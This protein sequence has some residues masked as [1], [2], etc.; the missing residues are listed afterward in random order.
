MTTIPPR[1]VPVGDN[2]LSELNQMLDWHAG[3]LLPD[4][5]LIGKL[6]RRPNKRVEPQSIPDR[7]IESLNQ[8]FP[9]A[10]RKVLEIGCF[11]GI[12]TIGLR[13]MGA[14]VTAVDVRPI[15]VVKTLAR[16]SYHGYSASVFQADAESLDPSLGPVDLVF[17]FG[18]LYHLL[19]PVEHIMALG[20]TT[21]ALY[22]DTH[23]AWENAKI[24]T[25]LVDGESY[26]SAVYTEGGWSDPFSGK[27]AKSYWLTQDSL[28][29]ALTRAGFSSIAVLEQRAERNGPRVLIY[30]TSGPLPPELAGRE[31]VKL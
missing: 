22:L 12:H 30:A 15:N 31:P 26:E 25:L 9:L 24:H 2:H 17:H 4:G 7:R 18:V 16:L 10:G 8:F 14:D 3:T 11:E 28:L 1:R 29:R 19:H 27:D 5:R 23:V 13:M 20:R 6:A 21:G